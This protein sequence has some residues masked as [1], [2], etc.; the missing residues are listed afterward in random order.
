MC[1]ECLWYFLYFSELLFSCFI[2]RLCVCFAVC[3]ALLLSLI[4]ML[5]L[6]HFYHSQT[7]I[8][9]YLSVMHGITPSHAHTH[10]HA[11]AA[12]IVACTYAQFIC[13]VSNLS[14]HF[15]RKPRLSASERQS[16]NRGEH[17]KS[18]VLLPF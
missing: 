6:E 9:F 12:H 3:L 7:T 1:G 16:R 13:K 11:H 4:T 10:K 5:L 17:I 8:H 15:N 18:H 2:L 14:L